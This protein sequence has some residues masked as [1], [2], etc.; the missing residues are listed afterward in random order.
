MMQIW[1]SVGKLLHF[2][3]GEKLVFLNCRYDCK[4]K[5]ACDYCVDI[6]LKNLLLMAVNI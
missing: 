2:K 3:N 5:L 1:T 6:V 4:L